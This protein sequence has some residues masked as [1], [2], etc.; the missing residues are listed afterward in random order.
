MTI[1]ELAILVRD[2]RNAQSVYFAT[3]SHEALKLARRREAVLD[4][5]I[6]AILFESAPP[7]DLDINHD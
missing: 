6:A 7:A 5:A 3:R 4:H 2:T 1:V